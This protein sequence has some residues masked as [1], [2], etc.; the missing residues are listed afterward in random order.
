V[1]PVRWRFLPTQGEMARGTGDYPRRFLR[2][3][4]MLRTNHKARPGG[5]RLVPPAGFSF[6]PTQGGP[7]HDAFHLFFFF[8]FGHPG[9]RFVSPPRIPPASARSGLGGLTW[10]H[11]L[12]R[13]RPR[14][15]HTKKRGPVT[16]GIVSVIFIFQFGA[17]VPVENLRTRKMRRLRMG[18]RSVNGGADKHTAL[19]L[20]RTFGS[21]VSPA[22]Q[23][24]GKSSRFFRFLRVPWK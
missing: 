14:A 6:R 8:L 12:G 5:C 2:L 19:L 23:A 4:D 10:P 22:R 16:T 9:P 13:R 24:G 3:G 7:S 17:G 11:L 1:K 20:G 21:V 18:I 15:G